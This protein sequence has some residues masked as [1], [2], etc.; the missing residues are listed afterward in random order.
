MLVNLFRL[1]KKRSVSQSHVKAESVQGASL[2][3]ALALETKNE[4]DEW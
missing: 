2:T 1:E 3:Q 4:Q